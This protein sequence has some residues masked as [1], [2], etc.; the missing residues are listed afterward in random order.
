MKIRYVSTALNLF[1]SIFNLGDYL[2]TGSDINLIMAFISAGVAY[3]VFSYTKT[4]RSRK[5][6]HPNFGKTRESKGTITK[7]NE[8]PVISDGFAWVGLFHTEG[9]AVMQWMYTTLKKE[10]P[11]WY[12]EEMLKRVKLK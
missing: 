10:L 7:V 8:V 9:F 4:A 6:W 3:W 12:K 1:A 11:S 2:Y 5:T